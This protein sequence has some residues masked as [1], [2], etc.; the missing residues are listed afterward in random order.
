MGSTVEN[1]P[2]PLKQNE[3][4][5]GETLIPEKVFNQSVNFELIDLLDK[6]IECYNSNIKQSRRKSANKQYYEHF[7]DTQIYERHEKKN[8]Y[9][10]LLFKE[11]K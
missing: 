8:R 3:F 11:A 10:D 6:S 7:T 1:T 4:L 9:K 2:D 5:T